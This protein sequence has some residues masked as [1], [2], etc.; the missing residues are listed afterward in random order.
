MSGDR[1]IIRSA[2]SFATAPGRPRRLIYA[3][4]DAP[5]A[6]RIYGSAHRTVPNSQFNR[7]AGA[8]R[9]AGAKQVRYMVF[10]DEAHG[11]FQQQRLLTYPA[12]KA[13]FADALAR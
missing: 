10:D 4:G 7:F 5:P 6:V 2:T 11:V 3:R 12:M 13:F 9:E 1:L 8:L